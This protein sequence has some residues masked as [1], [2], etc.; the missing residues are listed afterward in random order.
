MKTLKM[1]MIE[2]GSEKIY[3]NVVKI[4]FNLSMDFLS[5]KID[6]EL[7]TG[8]TLWELLTDIAVIEIY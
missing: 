3:D 6:F 5:Q 2:D 1:I 7:S 8:E 4:E